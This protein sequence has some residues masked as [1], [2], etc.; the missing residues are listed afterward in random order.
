MTLQRAL[1]ALLE[2]TTTLLVALLAALLPLISRRVMPA[3]VAWIE[4]KLKLQACAH[5]GTRRRAPK[6]QRLD[7]PA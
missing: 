3:L 2:A 7:P 1:E 4:R 5:C 6:Q